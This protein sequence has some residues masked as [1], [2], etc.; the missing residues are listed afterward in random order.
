[1]FYNHKMWGRK[2]NWLTPW[3]PTLPLPLPLPQYLPLVVPVCGNLKENENCEQEYVTKVFH[4]S[5]DK[6]HSGTLACIKMN[7]EHV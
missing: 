3:A 1:M 4:F 6:F 2:C 5:R 7:T